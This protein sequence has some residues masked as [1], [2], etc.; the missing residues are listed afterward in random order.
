MNKGLDPVAEISQSFL[1]NLILK[2]L[3]LTYKEA[4]RNGEIRS[5]LNKELVRI[6]SE[7]RVIYRNELREI[8]DGLIEKSGSE[9]VHYIDAISSNLSVEADFYSSEFIQ[10]YRVLTSEKFGLSGIPDR[11]LKMEKSPVPSIIRTGNMPDNGIWNSDR[12]SLTAYS[13][14]VE[15]EYNSIVETGYVEYVRWGK[16]KT[17]VIKRHDRRK[18]LQIREKILKIQKGIMPERPKDAPCRYCDFTGICDVKSTLA[19][20]FF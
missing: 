12:L 3:A 6:C 20:K 16:V 10:D 19:S 1:H 7:L 18:I 14:L 11:L 4:V 13:I 5:F 8:D 15:E 17:A 2:E 9:I